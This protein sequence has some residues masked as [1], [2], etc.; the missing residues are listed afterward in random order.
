MIGKSH[1]EGMKIMIAELVS[2]AG[3]VSLD[4]NNKK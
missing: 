3:Q 1:L 2:N 4:D